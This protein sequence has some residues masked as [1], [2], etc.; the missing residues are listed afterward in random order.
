MIN[1]NDERQY[2]ID[3]IL[4]EY[5]YQKV[6]EICRGYKAGQGKEITPRE[7]ILMLIDYAIGKEN[8]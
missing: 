8:T 1:E 5:R 3:I 2:R 4:D 7:Y 6:L